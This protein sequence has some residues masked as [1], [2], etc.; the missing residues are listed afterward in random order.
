M[1]ERLH[2]LKRWIVLG[3]FLSF[4]TLKKYIFLEINCQELHMRLLVPFKFE[5]WLDQIIGSFDEDQLYWLIQKFLK[6]EQISDKVQ[7]RKIIEILQFYYLDR[8]GYCTKE[9]SVSLES[10]CRKFYKWPRTQRLLGFLIL[11]NYVK[12][13]N[14]SIET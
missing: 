14:V 3:Y 4:Q 1:D 10:Q 5:D 7:L 12:T 11:Q 8:K 6:G 2:G 9:K 13:Q